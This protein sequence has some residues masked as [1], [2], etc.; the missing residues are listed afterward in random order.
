MPSLQGMDS[1][2][3][4]IFPGRFTNTIPN[5]LFEGEGITFLLLTNNQPIMKDHVKFF[6]EG[7]HE[8]TPGLTL[9]ILHKPGEEEGLKAKTIALAVAEEREKFG[10]SWDRGVRNN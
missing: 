4:L 2:K 8:V 3:K 10:E 5:N 7:I 6:F 1:L 9:D